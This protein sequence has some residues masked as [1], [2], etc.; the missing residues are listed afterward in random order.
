MKNLALVLLSAAL[1][2]P[3]QSWSASR[4]ALG[5]G[6]GWQ[7][8]SEFR[9]F[10]NDDIL[11]MHFG[12]RL[13]QRW[14][15]ETLYFTSDTQ[16]DSNLDIQTSRLHLAAHYHLKPYKVI[17]PYFGSGIGE[18]VFKSEESSSHETLVNFSTGIYIAPTGWDWPI[19]LAYN[20]YYSAD[21]DLFDNTLMISFSHFFGPEIKPKSSEES[22]LTQGP[23]T[24]LLTESVYDNLEANEIEESKIEANEIEINSDDETETIISFKISDSCNLHNCN[25][26]EEGLSNNSPTPLPDIKIKFAV[27]SSEIPPGSEQAVEMLANY[28]KQN[29]H[30]QVIF[31]GHSD[32][33]GSRSYNKA[34]SI[35]RAVGLRSVLVTQYAVNPN[36]IKVLG[37]GEDRPVASND[38]PAGRA[39]NRRI[40]IQITPSVAA[41]REPF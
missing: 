7:N 25:A 24:A 9:D 20:S 19:R 37:Y 2:L 34:L 4:Y 1:L 38:S 18:T 39:K 30:Q 11:G 29:S 36:S 23:E 12:Y 6:A 16:G 26:A 35:K 3:C 10:K 21:S 13:N 32:A 27:D 14:G 22:P 17:Q 31:E 5:M 40:E 28:L 15:L 41:T 33:R 8:Y